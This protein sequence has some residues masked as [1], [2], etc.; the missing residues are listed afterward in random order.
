MARAPSGAETIAAAPTTA[1]AARSIWPLCAKLTVDTEAV[2]S[3][4]TR[5][6]PVMT[7]WGI[8]TVAVIAG[9]IRT[10]PPTPTSDPNTPAPNPRGTPRRVAVSRC[11]EV[12]TSHA[13]ACA[14][15]CC[16]RIEDE[17]NPDARGAS[18]GGGTALV[19]VHRDG[20]LQAVAAAAPRR[21]AARAEARRIVPRRARFPNAHDEDR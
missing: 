15:T 4:A 6:V 21:A 16:G 3:T 13:P 17:K 19:I 9:T 5:D 14:P 2:A 20:A 18:G 10:P 1:A 8:G 12:Y 7:R 11:A